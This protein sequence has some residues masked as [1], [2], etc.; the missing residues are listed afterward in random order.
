MK[1]LD[2]LLTKRTQTSIKSI[3]NSRPKVY[4][5]FFFV[6]KHVFFSPN[7]TIDL[8]TLE[9]K[10]IPFLLVNILCIEMCAE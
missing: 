10:E 1:W 4:H 7:F 6:R 5:S 9:N 3:A 2:I 8:P